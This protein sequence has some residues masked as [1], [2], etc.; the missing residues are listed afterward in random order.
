MNFIEYQRLSKDTAD[1]RREALERA[2][3]YIKSVR[4]VFRIEIGDKPHQYS[5][6]LGDPVKV[7]SGEIRVAVLANN[8]MTSIEA[9]V[10]VRAVEQE[11]GELDK[12]RDDEKKLA[13]FRNR[14][15]AVAQD[16]ANQ[17]NFPGVPEDADLFFYNS[18]TVGVIQRQGIS[19]VEIPSHLI[20]QD[21]VL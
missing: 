9:G 17:G 13:L 12:L 15:I 21:I 19:Y 14:F 1:Y 2:I 8:N 18:K 11:A 7:E 5:A 3:R 20:N 16:E 4:G 10:P 6:S